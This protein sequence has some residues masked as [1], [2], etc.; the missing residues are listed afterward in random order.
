[1]KLLIQDGI[2][3]INRAYFGVRPLTNRD[4]LFTHAI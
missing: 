2:S 3:V 1:M 4:G